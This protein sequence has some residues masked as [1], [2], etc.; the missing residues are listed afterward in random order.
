MPVEQAACSPPTPF[1]SRSADRPT[2]RESGES[3]VAPSTPAAIVRI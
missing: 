1:S 3:R 2:K